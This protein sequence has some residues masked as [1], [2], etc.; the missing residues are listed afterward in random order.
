MRDVFGGVPL[1]AAA[2]QGNV[3]LVALLLDFGADPR[4][5]D[6][7]GTTPIDLATRAHNEALV[8]V[9]LA[10]AATPVGNDRL[11]SIPS[12]EANQQPLLV[13]GGRLTHAGAPEHEST[14]S[15]GNWR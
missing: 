11:G 10:H 1:H 3:E 7:G 12:A 6:D 4:A 13:P 14:A 15:P 8:Q 9:L 2:A 5:A